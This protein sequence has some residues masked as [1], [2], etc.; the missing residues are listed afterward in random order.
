M[1]RTLLGVREMVQLVRSLL[2]EHED[3]Q[4][5]HKMLNEVAPACSPSAGHREGRFSGP[6]QSDSLSDLRL[7]AQERVFLKK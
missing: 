3:L 2:T 1:L 5:A 7:R 6:C 4:Y